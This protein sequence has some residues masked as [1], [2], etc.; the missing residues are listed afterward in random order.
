MHTENPLPKQMIQVFVGGVIC[1]IVASVAGCGPRAP[2]VAPANYR[3]SAA[4]W[5][6][7]NTKNPDR[8]SRAKNAIEKDH[9]AGLIGPD[10]HAWY[11]EIVTLAEAGQWERAQRKAI[12]F[13]RDQRR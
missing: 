6:A 13:R 5:T 10:E 12:A 1:G 7:T 4:L 2:A 9:Q 3:Y 8:L 11:A